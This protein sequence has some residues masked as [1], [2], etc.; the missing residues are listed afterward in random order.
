MHPSSVSGC[1]PAPRLSSRVPRFTHSYFLSWGLLGSRSTGNYHPVIYV[2]EFWL[3][4]KHLVALNSTV[5][6]VDLELSISPIS[7]WKFQVRV[8]SHRVRVLVAW[9][10]LAALN[11][12]DHCKCVRL[13]SFVVLLRSATVAWTRPPRK[14]VPAFCVGGRRA[15]FRR[16]GNNPPLTASCGTV[17][18]REMAPRLD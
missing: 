5:E 17:V 8:S 6:T 15:A 18:P 13:L 16:H 4:Q 14:I 2:N 12:P 9:S 3:Q 1:P 10:A 11:R 7:M